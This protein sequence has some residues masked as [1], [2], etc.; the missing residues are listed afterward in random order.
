MIDRHENPQSLAPQYPLSVLLIEDNPAD[1]ELCVA[2]LQKSD[3]EFQCDVV[4]RPSQFAQKLRDTVYDVI[5]S[6]YNLG[7]W[8]GLDALEILKKE[9]RDIPFIL[10]T[11]ALGDQ[12]AIECLE[13]GVTDYLLKD[14]LDRLPAVIAKALEEK[15]RRREQ[16]CADRWLKEN[17]AKFRALAEAIPTAVFIEQG[18]RCLYVNHAAEEITGY[19]RE[20]LLG[21]NFWSLIL[22]SSRKALTQ[23]AANR[24]NEDEMSG[25]QYEARII[26]KNGHVRWLDVTVGALRIDGKLAALISAVDV[27]DRKRA[28]L[29]MPA[30]ATAGS[31]RRD[32]QD[33]GSP[34]DALGAERKPFLVLG[35][36]AQSQFA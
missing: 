1:A 31:S 4:Q 7:D 13:Y 26:T 22:P 19:G 9:G 6:D 16:E 18:T 23:Q 32:L 5:L 20:E 24:T 14:R 27:T 21:M 11:A 34:A 3:F 17:E 2:A 36:R 15:G 33:K 10:V 35:A 12:A 29:R 8:T 28:D 30:P 25:S